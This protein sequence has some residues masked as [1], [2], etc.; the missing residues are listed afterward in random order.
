MAVL[1]YNNVSYWSAHKAYLEQVSI[2]Q[3]RERSRANA[4][5]LVYNYMAAFHWSLVKYGLQ[6]GIVWLDLINIL[7]VNYTQVL[8][9]HLPGWW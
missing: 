9:T 4:T 1:K 5:S 3:E 8:T 2:R 7:L 6:E